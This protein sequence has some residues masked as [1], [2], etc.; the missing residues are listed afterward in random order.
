MCVPVAALSKR[1]VCGMHFVDSDYMHAPTRYTTSRLTCNAVP[2]VFSHQN[3]PKVT[4]QRKKPADRVY[5]S[6]TR[7]K[8]KTTDH[9]QPQHNSTDIT[10]GRTFRNI[11]SIV[12]GGVL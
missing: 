12:Q 10:A 7:K 1:V 8:R 9:E 4:A 5:T 2:S 6:P 11:Y 3:A